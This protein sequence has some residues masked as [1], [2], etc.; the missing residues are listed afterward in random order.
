M[1]NF[2]LI[3]EKVCI[4]LFSNVRCQSVKLVLDAT[5]ADKL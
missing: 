1:F 2:S 3:N 5:E 4:F